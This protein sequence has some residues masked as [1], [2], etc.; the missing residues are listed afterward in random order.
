MI[1]NMQSIDT[2]L[3]TAEYD[4]DNIQMQIPQYNAIC[5][6]LPIQGICNSSRQNSSPNPTRYK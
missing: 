3:K 1:K 4:D 5:A 6:Q 2:T